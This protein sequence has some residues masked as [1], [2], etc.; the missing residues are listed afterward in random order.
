[1]KKV[2][3]V[4]TSSI[5]AFLAFNFSQSTNYHDGDIIFQTTGGQ[6][7]QAIQLATHSQ[8]SH[9]GVLFY[10]NGKWMVYE[11]VQPV[12]K[13]SLNDF[14]ARGKGTVM[15]LK[16]S[17]SLLTK[18]AITKLKAVFQSYENKN[19]DMAFNWSD[20][21]LYCSELVYK[22]YHIGLNVELCKPRKLKDFDLKNPIVKQELN[23]QY[24]NKIPLEEPMVSPSDISNSA[25]LEL[26]K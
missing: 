5:F 9:C 15:R 26:V 19:Y 17:S 3:L 24:G 23:K 20:K 25:L 1:M 18:E 21:A 12:S 2:F 16:N 8:Y 4:I 6:R 11:A 10:E 22:M 13:I 7:A 14:N